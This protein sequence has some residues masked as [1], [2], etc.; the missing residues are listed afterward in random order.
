MQ[1]EFDAAVF[2][3][4]VAGIAFA[5]IEDIVDVLADKR[6]QTEPMCDEFIGQNR[7]VDLDLDDVDGKGRDFGKDNSP[8]R[9]CERERD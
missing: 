2:A 8:K 5:S 4:L 3:V 9:I 7:G 6:Y 1:C